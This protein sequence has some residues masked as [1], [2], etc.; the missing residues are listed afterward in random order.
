MSAPPLFF[1]HEALNQIVTACDEVMGP[2]LTA[3]ELRSAVKTIDELVT[4]IIESVSLTKTK[5]YDTAIKQ[6][7]ERMCIVAGSSTNGNTKKKAIAKSLY[8]SAWKL[9]SHEELSF[10][11]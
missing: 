8:D 2:K 7:S 9:N 5:R 1:V 6:V 11:V 4:K 3:R 10:V